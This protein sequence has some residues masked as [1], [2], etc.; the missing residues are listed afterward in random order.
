[1][2]GLDLDA[3]SREPIHVPGAI[4]PHG[5]L[6]VIDRS[7][8]IR[9]VSAN[10]ATFLGVSPDAL[11]GAR[12]QAHVPASLWEALQLRM[13]TPARERETALA[14]TEA[15]PFDVSLQRSARGRWLVELERWSR[16][17]RTEA[18]RLPGR[19]LAALEME[20]DLRTLATACAEEVRSLTGYDRVMVYRFDDDW[21]GWVI[22]E[23]REPA[24]GSFLDH[25]FPASDIPEQARRLYLVNPVR[26]IPDAGYEPVPLLPPS[27]PDAP[28]PLDLSHSILRSVSPVHLRYLAN[29]GVRASVSFSI[30]LRDRLWGLV[31]CH[32][33]T[34]KAVSQDVRTASLFVTRLFA[35][36]LGVREQVMEGGR[37]ATV[38]AQLAEIRASLDRVRDPLDALGRASESLLGV[39]EAEGAAVFVGERALL[40]GRT[41][42]ERQVR[43]IVA[44][45]N[46]RGETDVYAT[47]SLARDLPAAAADVRDASGL[48]A[49]P[50]AGGGASWLLWFRPELLEQVTWAG[51]PE[52]PL[53]DDGAELSPR[54]SFASWVEVVKGRSAPWPRDVKR[55]ARAVREDLL[56]ASFRRARE[57]EVLAARLHQEREAV[58][59]E[60]DEV[61]ALV[62]HD[63]RSPLGALR[64]SVGALRRRLP[65]IPDP[66]ALAERL[67]R[68]DSAVER[69]A[70][71]VDELFAG[72]KLTSG[73][74]LSGPRAPTDLVPLA[75]RKADEYAEKSAAHEVRLELSEDRLV[76]IWDELAIDRILDNLLSNAVKYSPKGGEVVLSVRRDGSFAVAAVRDHGVGIPAADRSL[77]FR[78]FVRAS[79]ATRD[80]RGTGLGLAI[81]W[82]IA[83]EHGGTLEVESVEGRGSTFTLRLPLGEGC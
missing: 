75:R 37:A 31:S 35:L 40:V 39:V 47:R 67:A 16:E 72:S 36:R 20:A 64:L 51:N 57:L 82:R 23:S 81:A 42:S 15:F 78:P 48:L 30:V 41:P 25:H 74:A 18:L 52:K 33:Y 66:D 61:L 3:C 73:R 83:E 69:A 44:W 58:Q 2:I 29:L 19:R 70:R 65:E 32:H 49:M 4:Q 76:G 5:M 13:K 17:E 6:A 68:M 10:S 56:E 38:R 11:L 24:V 54:R 34:P 9:G 27:G 28:Q 53:D 45:L 1:M 80:M 14:G 55:A 22:A 77:V 59:R 7:G 12:L 63:L 26:V 60:R 79:N 50:I 8:T 71:L 62:T 21:H 46:G 43:A